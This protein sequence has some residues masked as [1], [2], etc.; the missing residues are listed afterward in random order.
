M[1][2]KFG[3]LVFTIVL[4]TIFS[5]GGDNSTGN[6]NSG[7]NQVVTISVDDNFF[8]PKSV[9]IQPG[10]TVRW[11]LN[12]NMSNHTVTENNGAFDS[13]FRFQNSGDRFERTF[14]SAESDRTFLYHCESHWVSDEMQ[15]SV[16]VGN[17]A[18][19]P[20]PRY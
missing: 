8:S 7:G 18:P 6:N 13:G 15:G 4:L 2:K 19:A 14:S 5:C 9:T 11:V 17:N 16:R 20:P 12:G 10:T 3:A 1:F